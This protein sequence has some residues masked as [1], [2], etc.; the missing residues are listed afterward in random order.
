MSLVLVACF[1]LIIYAGILWSADKPK[2]AKERAEVEYA[3]YG[4]PDIYG[5]GATQWHWTT[6]DADESEK[7][8]KSGVAYS[9][10]RMA[11]REYR[12]Y[13]PHSIKKYFFSNKDAF[14]KKCNQLG[15]NPRLD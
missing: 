2:E 4:C 10:K 5:R 15:F 13:D 7:E 1:I 9:A 8:F 12:E 3:I 6:R 11:E 14:I